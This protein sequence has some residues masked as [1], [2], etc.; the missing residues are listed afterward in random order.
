[1][2]RTT[3][4]FKVYG[5]TEADLIRRAIVQINEFRDRADDD[6]SY[7]KYDMEL[8]V[9]EVV[10]ASETTYVANVLVKIKN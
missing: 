1:M 5:I 4:R 6:D 8:D 2:V 9:E 3:L 10:E 7:N